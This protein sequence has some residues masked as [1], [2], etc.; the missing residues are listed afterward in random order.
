MKG[1]R[2]VRVKDEEGETGRI[3][4]ERRRNKFGKRGEK[5]LEKNE[6]GK[7]GGRK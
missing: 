4:N 7:E 6:R 5:R 1:R 2:K 3:I